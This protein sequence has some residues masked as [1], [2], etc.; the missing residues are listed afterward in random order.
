MNAPFCR[1]VLAGLLCCTGVSCTTA[2]DAYGYPQQVVDPAA[3]VVGAAAV[4]LLA[5]G[6]ANSNNH[7]GHYRPYRSYYRENDYRPRSYGYSSY[8]YHRPY[9]GGYGNRCDY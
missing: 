7:H 6:L 1:F 2:Y 8:S 9:Y 3:A 4:G 5:Y